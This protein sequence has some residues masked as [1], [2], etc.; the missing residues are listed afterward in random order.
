MNTISF[1]QLLL[2]VSIPT[3]VALIG[4]IFNQVAIHRLDAK[5]DSKVD[6]LRAEMRADR[7]ELVGKI[8]KL[9]ERLHDDMNNIMG[10]DREMDKRV[11]KL[12]GEK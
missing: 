10:R 2:A 1:S 3:L 4:V 8:D 5:L 12:E 11:M 7:S 9:A 6:G